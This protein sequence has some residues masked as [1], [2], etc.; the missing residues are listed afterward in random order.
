MS[1][2][3]TAGQKRKL[4]G[5]CH[6]RMDDFLPPGGKDHNTPETDRNRGRTVVCDREHIGR[7]TEEVHKQK[8]LLKEMS[9]ELRRVKSLLDEM[10][11]TAEHRMFTVFWLLLDNPKD[12]LDVTLLRED[13]SARLQAIAETKNTTFDKFQAWLNIERER[14]TAVL[15]RFSA[16]VT[17]TTNRESDGGDVMCLASCGKCVL[18]EGWTSYNSQDYNTG[19]LPT[20][21][22][23][24]VDLLA[25]VEDCIRHCTETVDEYGLSEVRVGSVNDELPAKIATLLSSCSDVMD[26]LQH[27][28]GRMLAGELTVTCTEGDVMG[29]GEGETKKGREEP[30]RPIG[31]CSG[32][33]AILGKDA[34]APH[35]LSLKP[36]EKKDKCRK[37]S[38]AEKRESKEHRR[39]GAGLSAKMVH[40]RRR[41]SGSKVTVPSSERDISTMKERN[42]SPPLTP[43][44]EKRGRGAENRPP[45]APEKKSSD[46]RSATT[47]RSSK[48][49]ISYKD[50][51]PVETI[52]LR[53]SDDRHSTPQAEEEEEHDRSTP[54]KSDRA[55]DEEGGNEGDDSGPS[56]GQS[57]DTDEDDNSDDK[58]ASQSTGEDRSAASEGDD[59]PSPSRTLRSEGERQARNGSDIEEPVG[60]RQIVRHVSAT[61]KEDTFFAAV[62]ATAKLAG[63]TTEEG[64]QSHIAERGI[65]AV[66]G[67][68]NRI[69][70]TIRGEITWQ[71]KHWFWAEK[72]IP[73]VG[74]QQSDHH[75][76]A[77]NKM[78]AEMKENKTWRRSGDDP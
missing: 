3:T 76:P 78:R 32:N 67:E 66:I 40:R 71:L 46:D 58:S 35:V 15:K 26:A 63:E 24:V 47:H 7:L 31:V 4:G 23:S 22:R 28:R 30:D 2:F 13:M 8:V 10:T 33:E 72:G 53:G 6:A 57:Q 9:D 21:A 61:G 39:S 27:T 74:S 77:R 5:E 49:R 73:L 19:S 29:C 43:V 62:Q 36:A 70:T 42:E 64:L 51:R 55:E 68:C 14:R 50:E 34:P 75:L 65:R 56:R 38:G 12:I 25:F 60:D 59:S 52:D 41:K 16:H 17:K 48:K 44:G 69:M 37:K 11:E 45:R 1:T 18:K 54:E 20:T